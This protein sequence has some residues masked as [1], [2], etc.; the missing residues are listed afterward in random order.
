MLRDS[1]DVSRGETE[2]TMQFETKTDMSRGWLQVILALTLILF[3]ISNDFNRCLQSLMVRPQP[4]EI[5][6][7]SQ[8]QMF[9]T[10][11]AFPEFIIISK[12][13]RMVKKQECRA[14]P[15]GTRRMMTICPG[16]ETS[17]T[18]WGKL[19]SGDEIALR[20]WGKLCPGDEKSLRPWVK[21]CPGD[22]TSLR[23]WV[24]LFL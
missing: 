11:L 24:K 7:L 10:C 17:L 12:L 9:I 22:E 21:L 20:P 8:S 14:S 2:G 4:Q 18:P 1:E 15:S 3:I 19:C 5:S 13:L 23:P 6:L 16:D